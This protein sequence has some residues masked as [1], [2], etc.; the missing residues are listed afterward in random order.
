MILLDPFQLRLS[1]DYYIFCETALE[2]NN[3]TALAAVT[4]IGFWMGVTTA[5]EKL[6]SWGRLMRISQP[7]SENKI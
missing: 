3:F 4:R 1:C 2:E 5:R 7:K 6:Y